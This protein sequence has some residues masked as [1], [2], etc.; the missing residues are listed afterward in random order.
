MDNFKQQAA[1]RAV[2]FIESGMV[3]GL[4]AGSTAL[5]AVQRIGQ[6]IHEGKLQ[7]LKDL[8]ARRKLV[9]PFKKSLVS[10]RCY[11]LFRSDASRRKPEVTEFMAWLQAE[12]QAA[13]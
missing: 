3:V 5:F 12:A 11:Y 9:A 6:L 2:E 13:A 7:Q 8:L 1:E 4:G 10:P